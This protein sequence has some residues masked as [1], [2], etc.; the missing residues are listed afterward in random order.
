MRGVPLI[1]TS[2]LQAVSALL[3]KLK[4][5]DATLMLAGVQPGVLEM[6]ERGGLAQAIGAGNVFWSA[7]QAI[8]EA[9]RRGCAH[10][11]SLRED[12]AKPPYRDA[13]AA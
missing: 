5:R 6:L 3:E 11:R 12:A 2:G 7:D 1:D 10:C 13:S 8:V 9:E 4:H